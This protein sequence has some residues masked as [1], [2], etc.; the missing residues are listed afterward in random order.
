VRARLGEPARSFWDGRSDLVER[1]VTFCGKQDR[2]LRWIG[3]FVRLLQ[4]GRRVERLFAC[5]SL[6]EQERFIAGEWDSFAWRQM[7]NLLFSRPVLD[8]VFAKEHFTHARTR[9]PALLFRE[10]LDRTFRRVP[11]NDNFYLHYAFH[12]TYPSTELCPAWLK[13]ENHE[14]V[15]RRL[16]CINLRTAPLEEELARLPARSVDCFNLS[17]AFDWMSEETFARLMREVARAARPGARLCYWTNIINTK[18]ELALVGDGAFTEL[19][20]L[21]ERLSQL[22]RTA[23]YSG[24]VVARVEG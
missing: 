8:R 11:I 22:S 10:E 6:E 12:G 18:R 14:A 23:G 19:V 1:G 13:R 20:D 16:D 5:T 17:N 21:G 9:D 24:C 2:Y 4:G 15:R 3:R 7:C